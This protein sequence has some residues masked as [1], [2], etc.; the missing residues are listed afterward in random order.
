M[1]NTPPADPSGRRTEVH[2]AGV[3][4]SFALRSHTVAALRGVDLHIDEPGFY[5]IMGSSGSGKTTLLH[6]LSGLDR[7]DAGTIEVAGQRIDMLSE[8]GL[9]RYR[10]HRIGVVFQQFNLIPTLTAIEN[11]ALPGVLDRQ[12]ARVGQARAAELLEALGLAD[13]RHHRPDAMSG[14][15]QQRVAIARALFFE[16]AVLFADEPT[17]NLDSSTSDQ[18]WRVL[19]DVV[20]RFR[21]TLLMVTHEP[22][23]A[24]HCRS[25]FLLRDGRI[26]GTFDVGTSD[27][28]ELASRA[29][30]LGW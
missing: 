27:A 28:A 10:R 1:P 8:T 19:H 20:E 3:T 23:A 11:V 25:V 5:A 14:G 18:M 29:Q 24:I 15:E 4:K 12:P 9:T 16:P 2:V 7:P 13:R 21:L 22:S 26:T 17:G 30:Q 6:L